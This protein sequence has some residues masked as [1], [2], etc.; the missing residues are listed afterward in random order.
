MHGFR[1]DAQGWS[2]P[3]GQSKIELLARI[4]LAFADEREPGPA[5]IA[6]G[7]LEADRDELAL[8]A[9]E[10]IDA[11]RTALIATLPDDGHAHLQWQLAC[12]RIS[13]S[14]PAFAAEFRAGRPCTMTKATGILPM[15]LVIGVLFGALAAACA[16][17]ISYHE[18]RQ[19]MLRLDQNPRRMALG[20]ASVT[21]VFFVLASVVLAFVLGEP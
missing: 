6:D 14:S 7:D 20:T 18:Y 5:E 12:Q 3:S 19:R 17:V 9:R 15:F 11:R 1:G 10:H 2:A 8:D 21:F 4:E 16:Y 13:R